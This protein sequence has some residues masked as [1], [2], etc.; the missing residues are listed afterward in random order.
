MKA[1]VS[2]LEGVPES[3]REELAALTPWNYTGNAAD[4]ALRVRAHLQLDM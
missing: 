1:F 2:T 3:A 4:M